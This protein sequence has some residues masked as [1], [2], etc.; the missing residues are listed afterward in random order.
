VIERL[1]IVMTFLVLA[2]VL[3][4][5]PDS[6]EPAD[7]A[8]GNSATAW[9]MTKSIVRQHLGRPLS[10]SF[11]D[12]SAWGGLEDISL[13]YLGD[14]RHRIAA[15]VDAFYRHDDPTRRSFVVELS[16]HGQLGWRLDKLYIHD[17]RRS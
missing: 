16:Y 9:S 14:C 2:W 11:P 8:C 13:N 4:S 7:P 6:D 17:P 15:F 1:L 3:F 12:P 5:S 10:V